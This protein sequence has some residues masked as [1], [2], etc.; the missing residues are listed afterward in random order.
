MIDLTGMNPWILVCLWLALG[1]VAWV[2][3]AV[4]NWGRKRS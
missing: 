2:V 4:M 1:V 3:W